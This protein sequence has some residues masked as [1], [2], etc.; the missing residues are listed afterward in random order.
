MVQIDQ[1]QF[2]GSEELRDVYK[3]PSSEE[4]TSSPLLLQA[5][6][7]GPVDHVKSDSSNKSISNSSKPSQVNSLVDCH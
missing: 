7:N 3:I 6:R 2:L 4:S 5:L 1:S